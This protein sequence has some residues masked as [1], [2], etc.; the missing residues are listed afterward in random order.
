[1]LKPLS[2]L[3]LATLLCAPL[4]AGAPKTPAPRHFVTG[5]EAATRLPAPP[6]PGSLA[7]RAELNLCLQV[8]AWR[9]PELVALAQKVDGGSVWDYAEVLG[10]GFSAQA[11]PATARLL[12]QVGDDTQALTLKA[13]DHFTRKRPPYADPRIH[14]CVKVSDTGSYPSGHSSQIYAGA[15][16]L[17]ELLPEYREALLA[18]ADRNAWTRIP[19][20]AHFPT[21]VE[22][23]RLL[24]EALLGEFRKSPEFQAMAE[25]ARKELTSLL[26]KKAS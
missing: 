24:A 13:K 23:G 12:A 25:A 5:D 16:V 21:D 9:S 2:C 4:C 26:L 14:P 18:L 15:L 10:P 22:G 19:A 20:G 8:Q 3:V 7:A 17:A 11:L 6:A 1:M